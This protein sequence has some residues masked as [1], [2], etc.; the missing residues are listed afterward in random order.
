MKPILLLMVFALVLFSCGKT[1]KEKAFATFNDGVS[2]NLNAISAFENGN[3][4]NAVSLN[5]QSI[6]KFKETIKID[7][8]HS[9]AVAALGHSLYLDKQYNSAI[10]WFNKSKKMHPEVMTA[11]VYKEMGLCKI[12]LGHIEEGKVDLNKSLN[13]DTT[14]EAR[15]FLALDLNDIGILAFSYGEDYVKQSETEKGNTYRKF[16]IQ[17]LSLAFEYDNSN[18]DIALKISDFAEKTGDKVTAAKYQKLAE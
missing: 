11:A 16:A 3:I 18:K 9:G 10:Y 15:G 1:K 13:L 7:S 5:K 12:N 17:V 2:L 6:D 14:K 4:E 8:T